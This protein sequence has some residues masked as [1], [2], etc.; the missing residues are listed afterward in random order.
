MEAFSPKIKPALEP[1]G[2]FFHVAAGGGREERGSASCVW[3]L[4]LGDT[5]S[6]WM[7]GTSSEAWPWGRWVLHHC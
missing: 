5:G 6:T 4:A 1:G 7:G 2:M 3:L